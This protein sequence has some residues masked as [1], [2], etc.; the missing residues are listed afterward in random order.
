L[1]L[2]AP[3]LDES[4]NHPVASEEQ[5]KTSSSSSSTDAALSTDGAGAVTQSDA[6]E[7]T[8]KDEGLE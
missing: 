3:K 4:G 8:D 2:K 1:L 7:P 5:A 6:N